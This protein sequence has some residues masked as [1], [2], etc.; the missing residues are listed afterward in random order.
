MALKVELKDTHRLTETEIEEIANLSQKAQGHF[1][2]GFLTKAK[3]QW[4]L[5]T[6]CWD[7]TKLKGW[8]YSS[9]ERIG[10]TPSFLLGPGYIEPNGRA[11]SVLKN[12][13]GENYKKA[14]LAF[15]DEDVLVGAR[16]IDPKAFLIFRNLS[17]VL[18]RFN[19]KPTGEER[20]WGRRLAKR[21]GLESCYDDRSFT[22]KGNGE[23]PSVF[24]FDSPK[25]SP[26]QEVIELF[27]PL[28]KENKDTLIAFGWAMAENLL[29][30]KYMK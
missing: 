1:D 18:P 5:I 23:A 8:A 4:V 7:G 21:F 19:Y 24:E 29:A 15:P 22:V 2:E 12:I 17:D 3:E 20:A 11:D 10:G 26:S 6:R 27:K 16:L 28:D 14:L 25:F 30:G 13:M 9:L